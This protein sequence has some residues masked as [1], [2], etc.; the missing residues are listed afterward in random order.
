ME[1]REINLDI[2]DAFE[3]AFNC[4]VVSFNCNT[5]TNYYFYNHIFEDSCNVSIKV[6]ETD[7]HRLNI[8]KSVYTIDDIYQG[9]VPELFKNDAEIKLKSI[10]Q[11]REFCE[12]LIQLEFIAINFESFLSVLIDIGWKKYSKEFDDL[13]EKELSK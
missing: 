9:L 11:S 8:D 10:S 5:S 13:I 12:R 1:A 2:I 6:I 3:V 7:L 4:K